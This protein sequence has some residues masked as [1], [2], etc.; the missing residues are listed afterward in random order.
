MKLKTGKQQRT[1]RKHKIGFL[2]RSIKLI[3]FQLGQPREKKTELQISEMK[4]E[5]SLLIPWTLKGK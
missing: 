1:S 2:E 5:A 4:Q 3:N